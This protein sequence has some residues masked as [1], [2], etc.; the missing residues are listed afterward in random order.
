[1]SAFLDGDFRGME[2]NLMTGIPDL[3]GWGRGTQSA[4]SLWGVPR[5]LAP[6]GWLHI[7]VINKTACMPTSKP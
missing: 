6:K 7:T 5:V 3:K 2:Y 4:E 1:M